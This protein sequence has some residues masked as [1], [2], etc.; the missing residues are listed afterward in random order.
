MRGPGLGNPA[1]SCRGQFRQPME[2]AAGFL[3]EGLAHAPHFG[4]NRIVF[5]AFNL[6]SVRP[7][8]QITG[9]RRPAW[10]ATSSMRPMSWAL[11]RCLQFHVSR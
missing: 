8:V 1:A 11:A 9:S 4:N 5:H 10:V 3:P 2:V 6:P 7:G